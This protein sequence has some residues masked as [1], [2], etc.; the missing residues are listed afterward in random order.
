MSACKMAM[1]PKLDHGLG[2]NFID[3]PGL[4][5]NDVNFNIFGINSKV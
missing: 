2:P 3:L 1:K 4:N 5:A